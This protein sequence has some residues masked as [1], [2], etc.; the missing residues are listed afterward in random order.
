MRSS[1]DGPAAAAAARGALRVALM[2]VAAA[3]GA[4]GLWLARDVLL[5]G[6]VAILVAVVLSFPVGWLSRLV[7]RGVAVVLVLLALVGAI[8]TLGLVAAPTISRQVDQLQQNAPRAIQ[9]AKQW[10]RRVEVKAGAATGQTAET[11]QRHAPEVL[12]AV[13][14]KAVP[15]L[16]HFVSGLTAVVLVIVLAAFLVAQPELYRRGLR[17]LV[18]REREAIFD[19]AWGR[20]RDR[21]RRWG[22]GILVAMAIRGTL[23][24]VGLL[25]VGI[26]DWLLLG[27]LT[28][29]GTFVPYLGAVSSAIPGLL[30][31]LAQS[32]HH[33]ALALVVYL[34]VHV[35]DGY[36]VEPAVMRR[37]VELKP[38]VLLFTQGVLGAVFGVLGIV[39]A[40]PLL[41]CAQALVEYLWVERRLRKQSA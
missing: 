26:Q 17:R 5:L 33:L 32:P 38:A 37:A 31:A 21:L 28:F 20:V 9:D 25:A 16:L 23:T 10:L 30:M 6:F 34:G 13:G 4:A 27:A 11:A 7:P 1:A 19:E 14:E 2:L 41:V 36:V 3:A 22:G 39:V 40:T 24:A 35:A 29:L 8:G 12:G 18:P 15:A